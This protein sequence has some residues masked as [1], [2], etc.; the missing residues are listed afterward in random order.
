[1]DFKIKKL[2]YQ[3]LLLT[4]YCFFLQGEH[5]YPDPAKWTDEE[6]GIPPDDVD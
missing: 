6:L 2:K 5:A 4:F 3:P 1:M